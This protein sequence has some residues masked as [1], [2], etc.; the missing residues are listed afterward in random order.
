MASE[1]LLTSMAA[2]LAEAAAR[3]EQLPELAEA[4]ARPEQLPELRSPHVE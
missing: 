1:G 4:A 3:P 2:E